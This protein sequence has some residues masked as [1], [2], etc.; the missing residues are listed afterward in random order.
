MLGLFAGVDVPCP[1]EAAVE[2]RLG[3][4]VAD[5]GPALAPD[6]ADVPLMLLGCDCPPTF[7]KRF[8]CCPWLFPC[9]PA[10]FGVEKSEGV[11]PLLAPKM[12]DL[13]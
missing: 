7:A 1:L 5:G 10:L 2:N 3:V 8:F 12:P 11:A 13:L 6:A 4:A 9:S